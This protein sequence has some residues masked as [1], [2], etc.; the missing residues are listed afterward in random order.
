M[1]SKAI[2]VLLVVF[3]IN[4]AVAEQF[5][6]YDSGICSFKLQD[7]KLSGEIED[8]IV[9]GVCRI[10]D[11]YKEMFGFAFPD[12]FRVKVTIFGTQDGFKKYQIEQ[13]GSVLSET[14]Y[15]TSNHGE[16]VT[17]V[18]HSTEKMIGMVFHEISHRILAYQIPWCPTWV[19]E[20]MAEYFE[21]LKVI[22]PNKRVFLQQSCSNWCKHWVKNGFPMELKKYVSLSH[23]EW[24]K[25]REKD[26][27]AA[28]TIGYSLVYF[29]LSHEN[30]EKVLKELLWEFK[31]Q[32]K[33]AKSLKVIND[34]YPGG[35]E[36]FERVW[37]KWIPRARQYRALRAL[38]VE[39]EKQ[40]KLA[41][42]AIQKN[43]QQPKDPN[44]PS[45]AG[46]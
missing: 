39:A 44:T 3:T 32:G 24:D 16:A 18:N 22:G 8:A 46:E 36:R 41:A 25:F 21:G 17:W 6:T 28:Y 7:Y 30:N 14:G 31:R 40:Q 11:T 35:V 38:R 34:C 45:S 4:T 23:E 9:F 10:V 15:F 12:D 2:I 42:A 29:M 13:C 19:N 27:N 43:D 20:G 37:R 33:E 1:K 5:V 26:I